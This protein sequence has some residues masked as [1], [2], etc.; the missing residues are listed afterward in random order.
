MPA[1]T[2][3]STESGVTSGMPWISEGSMRE[4]ITAAD[5]SAIRACGESRCVLAST[6]S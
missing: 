3:S 6:A 4:P 1:V 2:H 5:S